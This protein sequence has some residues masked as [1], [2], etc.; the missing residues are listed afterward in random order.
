MGIDYRHCW[1][2]VVQRHFALKDFVQPAKY[3]FL[4]LQKIRILF[5]HMFLNAI[6]YN[7]I[8]WLNLF[9]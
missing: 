6:T 1:K 8:K 7:A 4:E 9:K 3:V 2:C 5:H